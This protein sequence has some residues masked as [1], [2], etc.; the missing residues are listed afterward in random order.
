MDLRAL[1][2]SLSLLI[3]IVTFAQKAPPNASTLTIEQIMQGE[4][5][6][7]FLP[8]NIYWSDDSRTIYFSW[9]PDMDTLRSTYKVTLE[10]KTPVKVSEE[11]EKDLLI[12]GVYNEDQTKKIYSRNGDLF[13]RNFTTGETVQVTNTVNR[14]SNAQFSGDEQHIV[15]ESENNLFAW[16]SN[17]GALEQLTDFRSGE[18][19][20]ERKLPE[21][22][23]WLQDD[24]LEL[25]G[26]LAERKAV[27]EKRRKQ[28]EEMEPERPLTIRYG[29]KRLSGLS[30][31]PDLRFV[32]YRLTTSADDK[33]TI[34][35]NFVTE[36][37]YVE[38]ENARPKV[39]SPQD[40]HETGIYDRERDTTYTIDT[41]Q[42][43]GIYDKPAF[44]RDYHQGDEPYKTEYEKPREVI[45]H[46]PIF[47]EKGDAVVVVRSQDNKDR[48]I[49]SLDLAA[50]K[51]TLL[52][53][54]RDE[55]WIAGPGIS[56]WGG[57]GNI[58]WM[59]DQENLWFQSE[60][61]GYSH[62]YA[63]NVKTGE[64]KALTSGEFEI[65]EADLSQDEQYFY[66][67]ANAEGPHEQHFYRLPVG[68]G[69]LERITNVVGAHD[70]SLSPDEKYLAIRYS[71]S[72]KPWELYL[73]EN[74]PGAKMEQLTRSVTPD[75][76]RYQ[77]RDPEI[78]WFTARDR[79]KVPARVYRPAKP[80]RKGP[81]VVFV[82]GAGYLQN[83]HKWWSSY[84]RE[85]MFHNILV[86]NGY[87]VLDID[88]RASEGYGRGW[89]TAIYRHMGGKDLDDQV[90][91]AK[92]LVERYNI[93]PD[94][95]GIYGGSYGGFITLMAMFTA[96][97]TFKS[98][99]ALRSVTD[100]AHYN[101]GYT[102][103]ILNTPAEDSIAYHRSSPIYHAAGLQD[104]LLILHGMVDSNVQFQDVVRLAQRLIELRKDNWDFAVFPVEDHGFVEPS[105][106]AD[107]Y[108]RI[109][110]LFQET[111]GEE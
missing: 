43:P 91:G 69:K 16:D 45:I 76:Q 39:G 59:P 23:Q 4:K 96:P 67:S 18:D 81:A 27:R 108:K 12:Y 73:M 63:V 14:E 89:R 105:S 17:T 82:H 30:I 42:I 25:F 77:W 102:S 90:D 33:N 19:R 65:L 55:A 36:S 32:T 71:Y 49:M 72:N 62:L 110:N 8:E 44:L 31:S 15:F 40:T 104:N 83:V 57:S 87:T 20:P 68:G 88:Y 53:R 92:F 29:K 22:Q 46:G 111:L 1:F 97:G 21:Y 66:I 28:R 58:G 85:Y 84:Y 7:G 93:D 47:S 61:T 107:E 24:Q 56:R 100:W 37:G 78:V 103:A 54:Q 106:W 13:L 64:K 9:N 94:R 6:V 86:D 41:K 35:P 101:H 26:V 38:D 5:F 60:E 51:L 48:W 34:V 109:F 50:G 80:E 10:N 3:P 75:F 52:D 2:L 11:E 70:V 99:A 98:G 74:K 95:I 79:I